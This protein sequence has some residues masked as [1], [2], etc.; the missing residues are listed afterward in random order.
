M[1]RLIYALAAALVLAV[2]T[3]A[4]AKERIDQFDVVVD[5]AKS[6][7]VVVTETIDVQAEGAEIRRGIFRDLPRYFEN[8]GD[9]LPYSYDVLGVERDGRREHYVTSHEDNAFRIRIG[10]EDALLDSGPHQYVIRYRVRSQVRYFDQYDEVYWNATGN[11]W[12]FPIVH[13]R[14]TIVLPPGAHITQTSAYTGALGAKGSDFTYTQ[15]GSRSVFVTTRPLE[16]EEGLTV[17][18]GFAKGLIDP[19]SGAARGW[20]WWQRDGALAVLLASVLG[21]FWFLYRAY[22]RVGRDPPKGPVF[23]RYEAPSSY[24]P[25]AVHHIYYRGL[26]GNQALIATLMN[27]AV[28][29]RL[30]ID[31]SDKKATILTRASSIAHPDPEFAP[32]DLQLEREIFAGGNTKSLGGSY[33]SGFTAAYTQFKAQLTRSYGSAYFRWNAGYTVVALLI[34]IGVVIFAVKSAPHWTGWHTLAVLALAALN[35]AF[36]YLMPAPTVKGQETRTEIEGFRLYMETAEKLQLNAVQVGSDAPP[37]MTTQ[38]Y[39]K[40]LPYAVALGVE[41]P[42]TRHFEKLIPEEAASYHPAWTTTSW[43][44]AH[45]FAGLNDA[46]IANLNSGVTSALP[47]SSSSSGSGGGGSSGGGGGGG[48]GGGW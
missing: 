6:G 8:A 37:P 46:I 2:G 10:D 3:P 33:D 42:W 24:S 21:L 18:I 20:L 35:G 31:A 47:Q 38:R 30:I 29:G 40:F 44:A 14:A 22:E 26:Q 9:R 19:P 12:S 32:E 27:L 11:Y 23:P 43:G 7:D 4:S 17:A 1:R 48:G 16:A 45:S 5:V 15:E 34:T 36:M 39:E 28:K 13:A 25:A 41:A